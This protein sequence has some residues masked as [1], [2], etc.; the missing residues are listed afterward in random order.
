MNIHS[1]KINAFFDYIDDD[2]DLTESENDASPTGIS[3]QNSFHDVEKNMKPIQIDSA[4][5]YLEDSLP[6]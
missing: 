1:R 2:S 3:F 6:Q 5:D 4:E